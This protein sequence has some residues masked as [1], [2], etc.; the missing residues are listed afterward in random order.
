MAKTKLLDINLPNLDM[1]YR[2]A[3]YFGVIIVLNALYDRYLRKY[4][5]GNQYHEY[6]MIKKYLL[7]D[8]SLANSTKPIL[9]IHVDHEVNAR[10]WESFLSRN[11][12]KMNQ[13]YLYL[14]IKSIVD[15]CSGSFNICIIDDKSFSRIIPGWNIDVTKIASPLKQNFRKLA[16]TKILYYYGGMIV[17]KSFLCK[18]DLYTL[19]SNMETNSFVVETKNKHISADDYMVYPNS[20]FMGATKNHPAMKDMCD[21]MEVLCSQNYTSESD[22]QGKINGFCNEMINKKRMDRIDSKYVGVTN[23]SDEIVEIDHLLDSKFINFVE[24][25]L[26][27]YIPSDDI[28]QRT[29]Y[30]W[31]ARLSQEQVLESNTILSKH[32]LVNKDE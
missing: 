30:Q 24:D 1:I 5:E 21:Y 16:L 8:S 29:K 2:Y 26:G 10:S 6:E 28:L 19:Y 11:S 31:F 13:P 15:K 7:N 12:K 3:V 20:N 22:F 23:T 4:Q 9:W 32:I 25:I 14:T 17:P 27:I 18:K